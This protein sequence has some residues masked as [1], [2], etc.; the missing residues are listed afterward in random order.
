MAADFY[1]I[2]QPPQT[3]ERLDHW[4]ALDELPLSLDS[5]AWETAGIYG[6]TIADSAQVSGRSAAVRIRF[7][8]GSLTAEGGGTVAFVRIRPSGGMGAEA[9]TSE[10]VPELFR[11]RGISGSA[12][13]VTGQSMAVGRVVHLSCTGFA[14]AGQRCDGVRVR[15]GAGSAS[16]SADGDMQGQRQTAILLYP[17]SVQTGESF[18]ALRI[19]TDGLA[20]Q[21]STGGTLAALRIRHGSAGLTAESVQSA[22]F[23]RV[24]YGGGSASGTTAER[25]TALRIRTDALQADASVAFGTEATFERVRFGSGTTSAS[26][27]DAGIE[28]FRTR[29]L[30]GS[31]TVLSAE[32]VTALRIRMDVGTL[33]AESSQSFD[34]VRIRQDVLSSAAQGSASASWFRIRLS[35]GKTGASASSSLGLW[36]RIRTDAVGASASAGDSVTGYFVRGLTASGMVQSGQSSAFL[37]YRQGEMDGAAHGFGVFDPVRIIHLADSEPGRS[38]EIFTGNRVRLQSGTLGAGSDQSIAALRIR[39]GVAL[40]SS[41]SAESVSALRIRTDAVQAGGKASSSAAWE[42]VRLDAVSASASASGLAG[43]QMVRGLMAGGEG[44]TGGALAGIAVRGIGGEMLA[45]AGG[46][47][48]LAVVF[49]LAGSAVAQAGGELFLSRLM[50]G[51]GQGHAQSGASVFPSY[52]GWDWEGEATPPAPEWGPESFTPEPWEPLQENAAEWAVH[53]VP[54]QGWTQKHG[55][56]AKWR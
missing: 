56:A 42:R 17:S 23:E 44:Y 29:G 1:D 34:A 32:Q 48:A 13:A 27:G 38:G 39:R 14:T 25:F 19:R 45:Q 10:D 50:H 2:L 12:S 41:Q 37:R 49:H 55:G 40:G 24:R 22:V 7:A 21:V 35:A 43:F 11:T 26:A 20:D 51:A 53:N 8:S 9:S 31:D 46:S 36:L 30:S 54:A 4:G 18:T 3:L 6:L 15:L 28:L 5:L 47:L 33:T 52:K 16:A